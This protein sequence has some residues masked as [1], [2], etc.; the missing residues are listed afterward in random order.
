M[1]ELEIVNGID[2]RTLIKP[3]EVYVPW[4]EVGLVAQEAG[5]KLASWI[6][7]HGPI[8][9]I[10]AV[11]HGGTEGAGLIERVIPH[12]KLTYAKLRRVK[13]QA[14]GQSVAD[15]PPP[16]VEYF[17]DDAD[18][19]GKTVCLFDEVHESGSS[20]WAAG[21]R[22]LAAGPKE[23]VKVVLHYKPQCALEK[24]GAPDIIG[25]EIDPRYRLYPWELW[26]RVM[27]VRIA[28]MKSLATVA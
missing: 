10:V 3:D 4:A 16:E 23:L 5:L 17:P 25:A 24:Y 15:A 6:E 7:A 13:T 18:L 28:R 9:T 12:G 14:S 1:K 19:T 8:D 26:E 27:N 22:I 20:G 21:Q 2:P 11:K